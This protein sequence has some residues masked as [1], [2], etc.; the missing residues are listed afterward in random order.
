MIECDFDFM[1]NV[2]CTIS[3]SGQFNM[4]KPLKL[5]VQIFGHLRTFEQCAD[6]I[7]TYLLE[8]FDCD[9]FMHTWTE[10]ESKTK[11]WHKEKCALQTVDKNTLDRLKTYYNPKEIKVEAQQIPPADLERGCLHNKGVNPISAAGMN[12]ML[13]SQKQVNFIRKQYQK[14]HNTQYDYIVMIRP[15]VRLNTPLPF[16]EWN[17]EISETIDYPSRICA[18]NGSVKPQNITFISDLASDIFYFAKPEDMDMIIAA[19]DK[20]NFFDTQI[21]M[22]NP[23]SLITNT[24]FKN[25]IATLNLFYYLERDWS[26]IRKNPKKEKLR[27]KII[28]LKIS[29]DLIRLHLLSGLGHTLFHLNFTLFSSFVFDFTIGKKHA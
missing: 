1:E 26:I 23:E 22:W 20:I 3:H 9:V 24:L 25:G 15:D 4:T 10:T 7:R 21:P 12:F 17:R 13:H 2:L 16:E 14:K 11:T 6:S 28:K 29:P 8:P 18:V 5:A 27:K 19:F